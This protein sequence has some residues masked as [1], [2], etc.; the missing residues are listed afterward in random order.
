MITFNPQPATNPSVPLA[1]IRSF[2]YSLNSKQTYKNKVKCML[3]IY[4]ISKY[5]FFTGA[6]CG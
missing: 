3:D 5:F 6:I 1:G 2:A 4:I